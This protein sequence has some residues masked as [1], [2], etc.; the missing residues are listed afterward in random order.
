MKNH[1]QLGDLAEVSALLHPASHLLQHYKVHGAPIKLTTK[2]W[3]NGTIK[4]ALVR[5][6]DKSCMDNTV[7]LYQEIIDMINK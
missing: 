3:S 6:R 7:L 5:G 4:R 2:S 1:C